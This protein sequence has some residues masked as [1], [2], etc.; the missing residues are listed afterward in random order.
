MYRDIPK[1]EIKLDKT[2]GYLYFMD[3]THPLASKLG[4]VYH[5]RHVASLKEGRGL[6]SDEQVHHSDGDKTNNDPDNLEVLSATE[7]GKLHN[8][9]TPEDLPCSHC[10][11]SFQVRVTRRKTSSKRFC[12]QDCCRASR[13]KIKWPTAADLRTRVKASGY[14]AVGRQLGVSDNAVRKRLKNHP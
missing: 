6:T 13:E 1:Q 4:K 2:L 14:S 10:G 12:S 7:H 11:K 9:G 5:H 3:K 8:V